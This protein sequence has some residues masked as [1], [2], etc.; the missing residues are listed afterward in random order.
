M[1]P[2][3][4]KLNLDALN[5]E[6]STQDRVAILKQDSSGN[7]HV[8]GDRSSRSAS[9]DQRPTRP[10]DLDIHR[11]Q[12]AADNM[13]YLSHLGQVVPQASTSGDNKES[14]WIYLNL[15]ISMAQLHTI[16]VTP[17]F[18][19][20]AIRKMSTKLEISADGHKVRWKGGL[21]GTTLSREEEHAMD[22][23]NHSMHDNAGKIRHRRSKGSKTTS[24]SN[25]I[26]E[27]PSSEAQ[28]SGHHFSSGPMLHIS[29]GATSTILTS[30][31]R[32]K[33]GSAF[34]YQPQFY[35]GY[36]HA[37]HGSYLDSTGPSRSGGSSRVAHTLSRQNPNHQKNDEGIITF[38]SSPYFCSDASADSALLNSKPVRPVSPGHT[39]GLKRDPVEESPLRHH[40][41]CYFIPR[42]VAP[43]YVPPPDEPLIAFQPTQ[44][45]LT[46]ND[47]T[48]QPMELPVS[49]L[50]GV[51][52]ED[53]FALNVKV[54][55]VRQQE[56]PSAERAPFT[57]TRKR[58][59]YSYRIL[60]CKTLSL[61]PS[62]LPPPNYLFFTHSSSTDSRQ[63]F[64]DSV[65]ETSFSLGDE[66]F[67]T[68]AAFLHHWESGS[69][70]NDEID[71]GDSSC[72]DMLAMARAA[73]PDTLAV[74]DQA[75][76][77][78]N[79]DDT[80]KRQLE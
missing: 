10:L 26:S 14:S 16:S 54:C 59:R 61:Q 7:L 20:R 71:G 76:R 50:G 2:Q 74:G 13:E 56:Y 33:S 4:T 52:P 3:D 51:Y 37:S 21:E 29:A 45:T 18:I 70:S 27:E 72:L 38:F 77:M 75:F 62:K 69:T 34:D 57:G 9:P 66:N 42:F 64:F 67:P 1:L 53:N 25:I 40:D 17:T 23:A 36:K 49:G 46:G 32:A 44:L 48:P 28:T 78:T 12:I 47:E 41:A 63:S 31:T 5:Q 79:L 60:G 11:A 24:S 15:L 8:V 73:D 39:L 68:H 19:R 35:R 43:P 30:R 55:R 6:S 65:S 58:K 22:P 80:M